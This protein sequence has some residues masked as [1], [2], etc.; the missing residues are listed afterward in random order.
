MGELIEVM[1]AG[2]YLFQDESGP[3]EL[4]EKFSVALAEKGG[5]RRLSIWI[6]PAEAFAI[7]SKLGG[8]VPIRPLT[9][10]LASQLIREL[11]GRLSSVVITSHRDNVFYARL[12]VDAHGKRLDVDAR[13][14]DAIA[15]ALRLDAPILVVNDVFETGT[16]AA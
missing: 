13:P 9:I 7:S 2:V 12:V 10:D 4:R 6:G 15:L 14:S 8:E 1:V 5:A 11:G 3:T 16:A